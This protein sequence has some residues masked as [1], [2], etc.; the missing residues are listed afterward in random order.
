MLARDPRSEET[1][2]SDAPVT[3]AD[4]VPR[5]FGGSTGL[6]HVDV[7]LRSPL[8]TIYG[9]ANLLADGMFGRGV[10]E[11]R[12]DRSED[13][14]NSRLVTAHDG[15]GQHQARELVCKRHR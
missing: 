7:D 5:C 10:E 1:E 2:G 6:V 13:N 15:F 11:V 8:T 4:E 3:K 12:V 14:D 9:N